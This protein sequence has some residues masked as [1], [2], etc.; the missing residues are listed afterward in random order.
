MSWGLPGTYFQR[1][2]VSSPGYGNV[3]FYVAIQGKGSDILKFFAEKK[4]NS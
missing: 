1:H 3:E 4:I 2:G